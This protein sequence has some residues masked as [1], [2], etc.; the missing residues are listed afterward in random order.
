MKKILIAFLMLLF[1][2]A[3]CVY[4]FIPK[5]LTV[6]HSV[7]AKINDKW[8]FKYLMNSTEWRKWWPLDSPQQTNA[9]SLLHYDDLSFKPDSL[10][11]NAL[12][13]TIG[14]D[15]SYMNSK[16]LVLPVKKDEVQID[17]Q[18][19]LDGSNNPFTRWQQYRRAVAVKKSIAGILA[20]Y[21]QW[22]EVPENI[23]GIDVREGKIID[24]LLIAKRVMLTSYPNV[25]QVDS[26]MQIL[27][28]HISINGAFVTGYPMLNII[29]E[30]PGVY[31]TQVALPIN[32]VVPET[33]SIR[34]RRMFAGDAL[35]AKIK[36]GPYTIAKA[37]EACE[38]YKQDYQ[39]TSPAVPF[40][41]MI[42][43]RMAIP[44]TARW[45]TIIYY[46]IH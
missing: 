44:D 27:R 37:Y 34:I 12:T 41:S 1:A 36:G 30:G 10:F 45:E 28:N 43:D 35:V 4:V 8:A 22:L 9:D 26:V 3:V 11:Y 17:W 6:Y 19:I 40:Q 16:L 39:K 42:T 33:D 14:K 23:Y 20:R 24:T 15:G 7:T 18:C 5:Q 25:S 21:K 38:N 13:I 32:K 29:N 31:N 2:A 46:P